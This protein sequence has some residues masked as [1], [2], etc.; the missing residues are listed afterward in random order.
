MEF[1]SNRDVLAAFEA[2]VS[3]GQELTSDSFIDEDDDD[4][5]AGETFIPES[6]AERAVSETQNANNSGQ[7]ADETEGGTENA[8][9]S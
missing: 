3:E 2:I 1:L 6:E 5:A 7:S 8:D 4:E 9:I